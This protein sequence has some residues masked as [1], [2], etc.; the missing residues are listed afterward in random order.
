MGFVIILYRYNIIVRRHSLS[1]PCLLIITRIIKHDYELMKC[2][3]CGFE[4]ITS[5]FGANK[6][7]NKKNFYFKYLDHNNLIKY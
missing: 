6:A 2:R 7:K 3:R 5:I 4:M 1:P